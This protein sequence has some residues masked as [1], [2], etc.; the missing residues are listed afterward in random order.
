MKN[1]KNVLLTERK[2]IAMPNWCMNNVQIS[3]EKETLEKIEVA[4]NNNELLKFLAPL[5]QDWDYGLAV[6]TWGTKW[7]V[8]EPYCDWDGDDTLQLSFDTAWGPPL[9]AYDIAESTMNLE[10]TASF[11]EPGMCFVGDREDSYE[12]DFEDENWAEY[13]PTDLIDDWGLEDEYDNWKEWQEEEE[14]G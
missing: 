2:E 6:N 1:S 9:G 7:D 5:G 3:G 4:A 12:F 8:N 11:Y 14:E 13:I 10:I